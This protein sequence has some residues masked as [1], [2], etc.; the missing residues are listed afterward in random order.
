MVFIYVMGLQKVFNKIILFGNVFQ[1]FLM[2]RIYLGFC[3]QS[4]KDVFIGNIS[5]KF[6]KSKDNEII[7]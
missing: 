2:Y 4:R 7:Y 6:F 1:K 3:Y 5:I